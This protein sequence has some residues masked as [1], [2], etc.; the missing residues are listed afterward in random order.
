MPNEL[1]GRKIAFLATD[2]VEKVELEQPRAAVQDAGGHVDLLSV[3]T[4][5]IAARNHDLE[6]AGTFVNEGSRRLQRS[7]ASLSLHM[8]SFSAPT[9][10]VIA[11]MTAALGSP[12]PMVV[13]APAFVPVRSSER[14]GAALAIVLLALLRERPSSL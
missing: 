13:G 9:I 3:K 8:I 11:L 2:G 5:E 1:Q 12:K 7:I 14:P 10:S 6:P 4:G